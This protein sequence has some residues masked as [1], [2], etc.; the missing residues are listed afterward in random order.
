MTY[1]YW[2][3]YRYLMARKERFLSLINLVSILGIA[4]GVAALIVVIGVMSGFDREL[5]DKIIGTSAHILIERPSGVKDF[6]ALRA[7]LADMPAVEGITPYVHGNVFLEHGSQAYG[8][9]LRGVDPSREGSVTLINRYLKDGYTISS[10]KKDEIVVGQELARYYGF[11]PGDRITLLS[12]VSG[13][14]GSGWRHN[15]RIAAVFESGMYDYDRNL[16]LMPL[17]NA[18]RIFDLSPDLAT[19]LAVRLRNV[20]EAPLVKKEFLKALG[21]SYEIRTWIEQ[22]ENFFAAL[23]LEKFAMFVILTLIVLVAAFNIIS[24]LIVTVTSKTKDIGVLKAIGVPASAIRRIFT[25]YGL[26]LGMIGTFWGLAAGM[27][28]AYILKE[29]ELIKLPKTIYY[30]DHLPVAIQ[31]SDVLLICGSAVLISYLATIYPAARASALEPVEA[32]RY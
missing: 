2:L 14:A 28:I 31:L 9:V 1:E 19:G 12:P 3:S 6:E 22:N 4:I 24:T 21:F 18:Q 27:G 7:R 29:T 32:L 8:M 23:N 25:L 13:V 15:F 16:V 20:D 10:L 30:I 11:K 5:K 17:A 26:A